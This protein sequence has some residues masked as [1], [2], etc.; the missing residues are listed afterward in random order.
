MCDLTS[1]QWH[2]PLMKVSSTWSVTP[3]P[4]ILTPS[5]LSCSTWT[6]IHKHDSIGAHVCEWM[7]P[8]KH[9]TLLFLRD[10]RTS[11]HDKFKFVS[12]EIEERSTEGCFDVLQQRPSWCL[13]APLVCHPWWWLEHWEHRACHRSLVERPYLG[14]S[15]KLLACLFVL[16]ETYSSFL[17]GYVRYNIHVHVLVKLAQGGCW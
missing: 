16:D 10:K 11:E 5:V 7:A 3:T 12:F 2:A 9:V 13:A 6:S 14:S 17:W 8:K 4:M 15:P 1:V